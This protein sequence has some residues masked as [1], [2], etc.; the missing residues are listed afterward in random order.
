MK[1]LFENWRKHLEEGE[2][3]IETEEE[4]ESPAVD[5]VRDLLC[6]ALNEMFDGSPPLGT[7][8]T[9]GDPES[10]DKKQ[11]VYAPEATSCVV[12][13]TGPTI[14]QK[15]V[16]RGLGGNIGYDEPTGIPLEEDSE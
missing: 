12:P 8:I 14:M 5:S 9:I 13:Y 10:K 7:L 1:H 4:F 6:Q 16:A 11:F 15:K 2:E 3:E